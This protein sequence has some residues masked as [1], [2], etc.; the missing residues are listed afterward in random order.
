MKNY[1]KINLKKL[2]ILFILFMTL[3]V[4]PSLQPRSNQKTNN[5]FFFQF[6]DH[7]NFL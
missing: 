2:I 3:S 6:F 1:I 5:Q 7:T 4:G